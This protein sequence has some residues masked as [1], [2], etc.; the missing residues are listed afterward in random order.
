V[1]AIEAAAIEPAV[2][3]KV[4]P[5]A[6]VIGEAPTLKLD[7]VIEQLTVVIVI[8]PGFVVPCKEQIDPLTPVIFKFPLEVPEKLNIGATDPVP[9]TPSDI[10]LVPLAE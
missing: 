1:Q 2:I 7:D 6:S 9:G 10:V 3:S 5:L 4:V 8:E